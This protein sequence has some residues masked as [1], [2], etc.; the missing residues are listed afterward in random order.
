MSSWPRAGVGSG[1]SSM[2]SPEGPFGLG[3]AQRFH[4]CAKYPAYSELR[5]ESFRAPMFRPTISDLAARARLLGPR[6]KRAFPSARNPS[7]IDDLT[8]PV[9]NHPTAADPTAA[10]QGQRSRSLLEPAR[11]M[12]RPTVPLDAMAR[13]RA[14]STLSLDNA[15]RGRVVVKAARL[16]H[17]RELS[18]SR[19]AYRWAMRARRRRG[20]MRA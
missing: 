3:D 8:G 18:A 4:R 17:G 11:S 10:R 7:R 5:Q 15:A 14:L 13:A 2:R 20:P 19:R 16:L 12:T 6:V 1:T 9:H